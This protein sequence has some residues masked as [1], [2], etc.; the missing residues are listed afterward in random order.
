VSAVRPANGPADITVSVDII[1]SLHDH[2]YRYISRTP[3]ISCLLFQV[4]LSEPILSR[5]DIL[6]VVRDEC[7]PMEDQR[8]AEF[9]CKSHLKHHPRASL[10]DSEPLSVDSDVIPIPQSLLRKYLVNYYVLI[11]ISF[12]RVTSQPTCLLT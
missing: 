11:C 7:D 6:C 9:V 3:Q 8:L 10:T 2:S 12:L 4:N 5:F 1:F